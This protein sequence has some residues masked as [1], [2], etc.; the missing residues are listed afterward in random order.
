MFYIVR[1]AA[2]DGRGRLRFQQYSE[3]GSHYDFKLL[4]A[5]HRDQQHPVERVN[6][7]QPLKAR[8]LCSAHRRELEPS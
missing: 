4:D 8:L 7:L 5:S 1:A 6:R 2:G 3:V